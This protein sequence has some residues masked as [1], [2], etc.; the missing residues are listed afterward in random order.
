MGRSHQWS[1][2]ID[3]SLCPK[4]KHVWAVGTTRQN[5]HAYGSSGSYLSFANNRERP[6]FQT[7]RQNERNYPT[8]SKSTVS[9][10][11]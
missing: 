6:E 4:G 5:G 10:D 3:T 7:E 1:H 8:T 9:P 2:C 11:I